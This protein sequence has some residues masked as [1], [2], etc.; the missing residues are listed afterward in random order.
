M[1]LLRPVLV[2]LSPVCGGI[3]GGFLPDLI[4]EAE[5]WADD[6]VNGPI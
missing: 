3:E 4:G 6:G 5:W 2:P 1:R